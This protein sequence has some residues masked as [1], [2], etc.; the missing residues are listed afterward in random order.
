MRFYETVIAQ[1]RKCLVSFFSMHA[2]K[3]LDQAPLVAIQLDMAVKN[4]RDVLRGILRYANGHGPWSIRLLDATA[5]PQTLLSLPASG[6]RGFIGHIGSPRIIKRLSTTPIPMLTI[7]EAPIS[8]SICCDNAAVAKAAAEMFLSRKFSSFAY[9][10]DSLDSDWSQSRRLV[11]VNEISRAGYSVST[12]VKRTSRHVSSNAADISGLT[13]WLKRLPPKTAMLVANDARALQVMDA[14]G[15]ARIAI[16][17]DIAILSCDNDEL[18]CETSTPPL[19]SIQMTTNE[20]GYLAAQL[21]D[22]LMRGHFT[23]EPSIIHYKFRNIVERTSTS[24]VRIESDPLVARSLAFLR[25]NYSISFTMDELAQKLH[26]SRRTIE[27]R[28]RETTGQTLHQTLEQIR[29]NAASVALQT[30]N[31]TI[32]DI[33]FSCGYATASH[34]DHVFKK[35]T[36]TSPKD[37]RH[38]NYR[39]PSSQSMNRSAD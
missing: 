1:S 37:F 25:L 34:F 10:S 19:S 35:K 36:G 9:V 24:N 5:Q 30:T 31:N 22:S 16:P 3:F 2:H 14:C 11:F 13:K 29:L 23:K 12:Y 17:R 28:F 7:D 20:A 18:L 8:G 32:E 39:G 21:L 33:A 6:F 38:A 27:N 15:R 26:A 4:M